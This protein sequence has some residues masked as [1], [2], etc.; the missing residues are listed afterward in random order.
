MNTR[1]P[2]AAGRLAARKRLRKRAYVHSGRLR[3]LSLI[4]FNAPLQPNRAKRMECVELAPA[5]GCVVRFES[6]SKLHALHT[7]REIRPRR[8]RSPPLR[9]SLFGFLSDFVIRPSD[10]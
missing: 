6:G 7:L 9:I 3:R 10:F 1:R 8:F 2:S 4:L 5:V